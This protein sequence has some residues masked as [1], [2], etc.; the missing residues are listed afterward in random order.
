MRTKD[1]KPI[2]ILS[3]EILRIRD[4]FID[5]ELIWFCNCVW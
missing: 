2:Y 5:F 1:I 3:F 4:V